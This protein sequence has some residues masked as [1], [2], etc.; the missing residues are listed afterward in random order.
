MKI[1]CFPFPATS[2]RQRERD[3]D[4]ETPSTQYRVQWRYFSSGTV[5]IFADG[6]LSDITSLKAFLRHPFPFSGLTL[7]THSRQN[8]SCKQLDE[9]GTEMGTWAA[10]LVHPGMR[11]TGLSCTISRNLHLT[12]FHSLLNFNECPNN[13]IGRSHL[14]WNKRPTCK[15]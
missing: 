11:F 15:H 7:P 1:H 12:S 6:R 8:S 5:K 3:A 10:F 2:T 14:E 4:E 13:F 9:P